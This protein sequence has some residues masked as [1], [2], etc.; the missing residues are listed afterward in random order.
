MHLENTDKTMINLIENC[1]EEI[2]D[3]SVFFKE[4]NKNHQA[5][6]KQFDKSSYVSDTIEGLS[7]V[8]P[9]F[10]PHEFRF[11]KRITAAQVQEKM[12]VANEFQTGEYDPSKIQSMIRATKETLIREQRPADCIIND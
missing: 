5:S 2:Q 10:I 12:K 1:T 9:K 4:F 8:E 3:M 6:Q 7:N 11:Q